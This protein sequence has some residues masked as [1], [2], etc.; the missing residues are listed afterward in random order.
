[1]DKR[2]MKRR[3]SF[4]IALYDFWGIEDISGVTVNANEAGE[5]RILINKDLS[6]A[7][8]L[9]TFLHEMTHIWRHD[10][11]RQNVQQIE[12]EVRQDLLKALEIVKDELK[13]AD[14]I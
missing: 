4:K 5:Y 3:E 6:P 2:G 8:Q 12:V 11:S 1:M 13:D 10:F 7:E 14:L 9:A